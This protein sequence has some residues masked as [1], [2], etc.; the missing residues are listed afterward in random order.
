MKVD[1]AGKG[2][3]DDPVRRQLSTN[4]VSGRSSEEV[5]VPPD[6]GDGHRLV[7]AFRSISDPKAR[8]AL[9]DLAEA[10]ARS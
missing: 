9:I 3:F 2:Q 8:Q 6:V 5:S 7:K 4:K 1:K 10:L